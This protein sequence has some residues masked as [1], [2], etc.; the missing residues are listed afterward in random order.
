MIQIPFMA[1]FCDVAVPVPLDMVF[2][3][4]VP[5]GFC[6]VPGS[7]V[8]VPFRRQRL[9]GIVTSLHDRAP[10]VSAKDVLGVLDEAD[11]PALVGELLRM[12]K[13]I[14][15]YYLAPLGEVFRTMLPL[16]AEFRRTVVYRITD[17]GHMAASGGQC[18][19]VRKIEK[20]A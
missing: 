17:E 8:V 16:N 19:I 12:G 18:Q 3:Y 7:R 15:E 2:T 20:N 9:V 13:W 4:R 5:E 10:K 6:L 11:A 14:S 1:Q